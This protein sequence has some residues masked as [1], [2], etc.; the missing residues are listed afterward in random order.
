MEAKEIPHTGPLSPPSYFERYRNRLLEM[1]STLGRRRVRTKRFVDPTEEDLSEEDGSRNGS[2]DVY[3]K[4]FK[5]IM[6]SGELHEISVDTHFMDI[7]T[8]LDRLLFPRN[9]EV[10]HEGWR[11]RDVHFGEYLPPTFSNVPPLMEQF[12][13]KVTQ[14]WLKPMSDEERFKLVAWMVWMIVSIH[15]KADGNGRF[16]QGVAEYLLTDQHILGFH[17]K[18]WSEFLHQATAETMQAISQKNGQPVPVFPPYPHDKNQVRSWM[19]TCA[20]LFNSFYR[21]NGHDWSAEILQEAIHQTGIDETGRVY[22]AGLTPQA[23]SKME[24]FL[25]SAPMKSVSSISSK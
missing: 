2:E 4:S 1:I 24:D 13:D 22:C 12:A 6:D 23:L 11:T 20:P 8:R 21:G 5:Y 18:L 25:K 7:L 9:G 17:N 14:L 3:R 15:P 10:L 16:S 19:R